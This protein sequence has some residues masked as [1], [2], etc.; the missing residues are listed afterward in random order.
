M[1]HVLSVALLVRGHHHEDITEELDKAMRA[2]ESGGAGYA[3][4]M[5]SRDTRSSKAMQADVY[6]AALNYCNP[7]ELCAV[8][9]REIDWGE[10]EAALIWSDEHDEVFT[11]QRLWPFIP[12]PDVC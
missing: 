1:S 9:G 4:K 6:I 2:L 5:V 11:Y 8:L 3:W 10:S 12:K 7:R